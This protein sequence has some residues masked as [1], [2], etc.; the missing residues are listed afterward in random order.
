[1]HRDLGQQAKGR[2][3]G[4]DAGSGSIWGGGPWTSGAGSL[5]FPREPGSPV[6]GREAVGRREYE[7]AKES[8]RVSGLRERTVTRQ[9]T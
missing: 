2:E 7:L 9:A 3:V 6:S 1:M 5:E 8:R 4:A